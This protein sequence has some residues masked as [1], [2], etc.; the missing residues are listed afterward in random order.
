MND[1]DRRLAGWVRETLYFDVEEGTRDDDAAQHILAEVYRRRDAEDRR[2][3]RRRRRLLC[4]GIVVGVM[5]SGSAAAALLWPWGQPTRPEVGVLCHASAELNSDAIVIAP[6]DDPVEGCARLWA[7]GELPTGEGPDAVPALVACIGPNGAIE[8][9]PGPNEVCAQ[10][11]LEAADPT[12][13]SDNSAIVALQDRLIQ[14]INLAACRPVRDVVAAVEEQLT[15]F[16]M[17]G[18]TVTVTPGAEAG[19]CG[20]VAV[21]TTN[22]TVLVVNDP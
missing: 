4:G 14:E 17:V 19:A 15:E 22:R 16:S 13:N 1:D 7:T 2:R 3:T 20:K 21:D 11:E 9:F 12:L 10:L 5:V 6:G 8:V 18:W